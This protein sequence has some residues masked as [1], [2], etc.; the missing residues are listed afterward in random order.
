MANVNIRVDIK[1]DFHDELVK[2]AMEETIDAC[3]E[4]CGI[5]CEGY[6]K[7]YIEG[8]GGHPKRVDTGRLVN[9][10]NHRVRKSENSVVIGTNVEYAPYVH[11]GTSKMAPNRFLR[12]A[13]EDYQEEYVQIFRDALK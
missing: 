3:L 9:S 7:L 6:A 4:K 11:E 5:N 2:K 1:D 10:I 8:Y 12:D 13:L